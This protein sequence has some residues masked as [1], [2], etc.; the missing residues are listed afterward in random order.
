MKQH[1]LSL[2]FLTFLLMQPIFS[3]T[4]YRVKYDLKFQ[5]DSTD[6][7][8]I[9]SDIMYLD[10]IKNEKSYFRSKSMF[11]KDSIL[12]SGNPQALFSVTKPKFKYCIK[13]H[14]RSD[15][16]EVYYDYTAF[17]FKLTQN[18]DLDWEI[19]QDP[20]KDIL[21]YKVNKAITTFKGREYTAWYTNEIAIQDGP[22]KFSGLPG[23]ILELY[24]MKNHY[25]FK[26]ISI[27]KISGYN[28]Y[29][30]VQDYKPITEKDFNEFEEKIKKKPSLIL[31]NPGIQIPKEGLDKYDRN[32]RERDMHK[33]NPIELTDE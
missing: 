13:K 6:T 23:L 5:I 9:D 14:Y 33:N 8:N 1:I 3:Q 29:S 21:G 20:T 19:T 7:E 11:L 2:T 18:V 32:H 31:N 15:E 16:L 4:N 28:S 25:H 17:K 22:Y 10:I 24:D 12:Q 26:A 30:A 27:Q